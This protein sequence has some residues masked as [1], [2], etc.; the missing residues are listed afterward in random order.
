VIDLIE[1]QDE[2]ALDS[3][4]VNSQSLSNEI[5]E[6]DLQPEKHDEQRI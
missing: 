5:H 3:V 1:E 6:S 2:N 4:C